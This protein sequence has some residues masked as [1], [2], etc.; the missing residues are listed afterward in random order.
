M[1]SLNLTQRLFS[2]EKR[3]KNRGV[4]LFNLGSEKNGKCYAL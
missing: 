2:P 1:F 3:E 4:R